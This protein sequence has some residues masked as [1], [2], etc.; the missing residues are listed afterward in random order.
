[1][2]QALCST[3]PLVRCVRDLCMVYTVKNV[4]VKPAERTWIMCFG[5]LFVLGSYLNLMVILTMDLSYMLN[6]HSKFAKTDLVP[7]WYDPLGDDD[8]DP[9]ADIKILYKTAPTCMRRHR[10][11]TSLSITYNQEYAD[12][13]TIV[14]PDFIVAMKNQLYYLMAPSVYPEDVDVFAVKSTKP[15]EQ[16][17]VRL[18]TVIQPGIVYITIR[19]KKPY[20][21][22]RLS[23]QMALNN[24]MRISQ[25]TGARI[26]EP[27][28]W[29]REHGGGLGKPDITGIG[30]VDKFPEGY[31]TFDMSVGNPYKHGKDMG[32]TEGVS[33]GRPTSRGVT[34]WALY[35]VYWTVG[36][37][38][39][40]AATMC[41]WGWEHQCEHHG[42]IRLTL[43]QNDDM[44][45]RQEWPWFMVLVLTIFRLDIVPEWM[46]VSKCN[47][48]FFGFTLLFLTNTTFQVIPCLIVQLYVGC[49]SGMGF[50]QPNLFAAVVVNFLL[51][52]ATGV[53]WE[54]SQAFAVKRIAIDLSYLTN[55]SVQVRVVPMLGA[56]RILEALCRVLPLVLIMIVYEEVYL[57]Y[58]LALD[59]VLIFLAMVW[60]VLLQG[61]HLGGDHLRC[62]CNSLFA[63]LGR[64]VFVAP[65]LVFFYLDTLTGRTRH[66]TYVNPVL[67]YM[68][69]GLSF[70]IVLF[71]VGV[72]P[73]LSTDYVFNATAPLPGQG[74]FQ[75]DTNV[76]QVQ[77]VSELV[78]VSWIV[79]AAGAVLVAFTFYTMRRYYGIHGT[80]E[81]HGVCPCWC[82]TT[83]VRKIVLAKVRPTR[84]IASEYV[85]E[86]EP[87]EKEEAELTE[88]EKLSAKLLAEVEATKA[89]ANHALEDALA[90]LD[91]DDSEEEEKSEVVR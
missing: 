31:K 69:R 54:R 22:G 25:L 36:V 67:Y 82:Y 64:F 50:S 4:P 40:V 16:L 2:Y 87:E 48:E 86:N 28:V 29:E 49:G 71:F 73:L 91:S 43:K 37:Q 20:V 34:E 56:Y 80:H 61:G 55:F 60:T 85:A 14:S 79:H 23:P 51:V 58:I 52:A 6:P 68:G 24:L 9:T 38:F 88:E 30:Y 10:E 7:D 45:F 89:G 63:F 76:H 84:D 12:E 65:V 75:N 78:T 11:L 47:K 42:D 27:W 18:G 15:K 32:V 5:I 57:F 39:V 21:W 1:M 44:Q 62:T 53:L 35:I 17:I 33:D 90:A 3:P 46:E 66:N 81:A 26:F 74:F 13:K 83:P 8:C 19:F 70:Y 77:R 59:L 72:D 41:H